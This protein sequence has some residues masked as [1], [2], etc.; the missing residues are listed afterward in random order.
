M[1]MNFTPSRNAVIRVTIS[2]LVIGL[3][4]AFTALASGTS[5][6][7]FIDSVQEFFGIQ[8]TSTAAPVPQTAEPVGI[9]AEPMAPLAVTL[10][11]NTFGNAGTETTEPS[12]ANDPNVAGANLTFGAGVTPAANANRFGGNNWFDIGDTAAGTTLPESITGNDYIQFTVTPNAGFSFTPTSLVFSWDRSATGPGN[13]TLRSSAN[14]FA[15]DIGSVTGMAASLT[16]GNTLT[17]SGVT[18]VTAATTFRLYGYGATATSG[19]GG[20][21][22]ASSVN[23]VV[24]NGTTAAVPTLGT[25]SSAVTG[26]SG[27]VVTANPSAAPANATSLTASTSSNFKGTFTVDSTT[28]AVRVTNAYPAGNYT[29]TVRVPQRRHLISR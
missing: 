8:P 17:I 26:L 22:T 15:T 1:Y 13:V 23:N 14:S 25:Y 5:R 9:A 18:N 11:W 6:F 12:T 27:N 3:V 4:L 24:L 28:G 19:T 7:A 29:V 20:F 10:S 21:D 2:S 16:T